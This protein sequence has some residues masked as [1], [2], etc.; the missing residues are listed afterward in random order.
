LRGVEYD[1][2]CK[3]P[4]K[5]QGVI[6]FQECPQANKWV[7]SKNGLSSSEW[8]NAIKM[9]GNVM[10]VN[11]I[12]RPD[13]GTLYCRHGCKKI[14]TLGHILGE[15][16][17]GELIRNNRHHAVRRLIADAMSKNGWK[18]LQEVECTGNGSRRV[19]IIAYNQA[20]KKGFI[21]DP[22]VRMEQNDTNQS[23]AVNLAKK[24]IYDPCIPYFCEK[25]GLDDIEVIGLYIGAR[26]TI[27]KFFLDFMKTQGLLSTLIEDIVV[28]VLKKSV[29]ICIHHLFST[30]PNT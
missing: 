27:S 4:K 16:H 14:E 21:L 10:P 23:E 30:V 20:T 15:C 8:T 13:Q 9:V 24:E 12:P 22:T 17:R 3:L 5:G 25:L 7:H 19:D 11:A 18:V 26:G 2:W 1:K 28:S 6:Q 29:Q